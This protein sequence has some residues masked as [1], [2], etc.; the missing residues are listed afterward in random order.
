MKF[1]ILANKYIERIVIKEVG[2]VVLASKNSIPSKI[3]STPTDLELLAVSISS[4][5]NITVCLIYNP[6]NSSTI[7]HTSLLN[8]IH[9]LSFIS[10]II[11]VGDLNLPDANWDTYTGISSFTKD[12]CEAV[13]DLTYCN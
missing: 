13:F 5:E 4:I 6:P 9:S 8:Y 3:L 2:G 1:Y 10:N 12:F 11:I 7:Y